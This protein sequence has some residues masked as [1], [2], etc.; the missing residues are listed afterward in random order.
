MIDFSSRPVFSL[1]FDV[2]RVLNALPLFKLF[3]IT[4][5]YFTIYHPVEE[6]GGER[7]HC[8]LEIYRSNF[9]YIKN[10]RKSART[11]S[12]SFGKNVVYTSKSMRRFD[13][14]KIR[15]MKIVL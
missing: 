7:K 4:L 3:K 11:Y 6:G 12:S 15:K 5:R 8:T 1:R 14:M 9:S 10:C 2:A 13:Q